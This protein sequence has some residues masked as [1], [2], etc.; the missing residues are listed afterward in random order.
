M[1]SRFEARSSSASPDVRMIVNLCILALL[2]RAVVPS[3]D[4]KLV[5]VLADD[6]LESLDLLRGGLLGGQ[7]RE[8]SACGWLARRP[9]HFLDTAGNEDEQHSAPLVANREPM[10][11]VARP[12]DIVTRAR[13]DGRA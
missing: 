9:D 6:R 10:G 2:T 1:C 13:L 5:T 11:D 4:E 7:G 8:S 12:E 3:S